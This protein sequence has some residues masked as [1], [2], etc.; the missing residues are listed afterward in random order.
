MMF[1]IVLPPGNQPVPELFP[2]CFPCTCRLHPHLIPHCLG[3]CLS[4]NPYFFSELVQFLPTRSQGLWSR[5]LHPTPPLEEDCYLINPTTPALHLKPTCGSL[6][7]LEDKV[8][9]P[10]GSIQCIYDLA[11]TPSQSHLLSQVSL[12]PEAWKYWF[13]ISITRG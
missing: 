3:F 2:A 5:V 13:H 7:Y 6:S 9:I 11:L 10:E 4:F 1:S 8:Q 12:Q